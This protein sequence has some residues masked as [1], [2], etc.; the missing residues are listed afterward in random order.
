MHTFDQSLLELYREHLITLEEAGDNA[1]S[2]NEFK[3]M[4]TRS[5]MR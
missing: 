3:V 2:P 5:G 4:V 1:T